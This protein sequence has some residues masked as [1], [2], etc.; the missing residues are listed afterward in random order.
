MQSSDELGTDLTEQ[1]GKLVTGANVGKT[2]SAALEAYMRQFANLGGK[3]KSKH[4][5]ARALRAQA[6]QMKR[7]FKRKKS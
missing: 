5:L 3:R 6:K 4:N 2:D 1:E 7:K